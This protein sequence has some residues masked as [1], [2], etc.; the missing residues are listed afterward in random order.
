MC[1]L[2]MLSGNDRSSPVAGFCGLCLAAR[3]KGF[4]D[5]V[6]GSLSVTGTNIG[7]GLNKR[8]VGVAR[9]TCPR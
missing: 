4:P 1:F 7:C 2:D 8:G 5:G 9:L 6:G 3:A